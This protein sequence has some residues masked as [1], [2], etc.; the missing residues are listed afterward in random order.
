[1]ADPL[2]PEEL[3]GLV[4]ELNL[5]AGRIKSVI[6]LADGEDE[7]SNTLGAPGAYA[8]KASPLT[9]YGPKDAVTGWPPGVVVTQGPQG[10]SAKQVI[11]AADLLP[12]DATDAEFAT[13][14]ANSQI[15]T[16]QPLL[17]D[18]EAARD[19]AQAARTGA[20]TAET[21]AE[22]A[23][24]SA[25][26]DA[27]ATEA[28]RVATGADRTAVAMD[29]AAAETARAAAEAA[30]TGAVAAQGAG[31]TAQA[32]AEAAQTAAE[33]AQ[34]FAEGSATS[35]ST[36]AAA[37][38]A[39]ADQTAADRV[40]T[41]A[42]RTAV[43]ADRSAVAADA[44]SVATDRAAV[45]AAMPDFSAAVAA[46]EQT[47]L[48]RIAT[49]ADAA[50]TAGDRA[51]VEAA[52]P[53]FAAAVAAAEQTT[54]DAA[55]TAA[56]AVQTGEDRTAVAAGK[57]DTLTAR[58]AALAAQAAAEAARDEAEAIS[59]G[60]FQTS[61]ATLT[62][63]A[64]LDAS[65]G[66]LVQTGA[67]AFAKRPIG[68]ATSTDILD[69]A[70]GDG[71]YA[72]PASI[73]SAISALVDGAPTALDTLN[74]IAAALAADDDAIAALILAVDG[75]QA[76]SDTLTALAALTTTTFGRALLE[77]ADAAALKSALAI[78]IADVSGL[79]TALA[80]RVQTVNGVAPDTSGNV[81]VEA[82]VSSVAGLT[83]AVSAAALNAA[84]SL[85]SEFAQIALT[86][87]DLRGDQQGMSAGIADAFDDQDGVS[88]VAGWT[89]D[90]TNDWYRSSSVMEQ[91]VTQTLPAMTSDAAPSPW[92][93]EGFN[94]AATRSPYRAFNQARETSESNVYRAAAGTWYL[95]RRTTSGQKYRIWRYR[96]ICFA[97][98]EGPNA[99]TLEARNNNTGSW[100]TL[101]TQTDQAWTSAGQS[102]D[103][104]IASGSRGLYSDY[105]L[106]VSSG[107]S[108]DEIE[109][110]QEV[111]ATTTPS[112]LTSTSFTAASAPTTAMVTVLLKVAAGSYALNTDVKAYV[113]RDSGTTW[114]QATLVSGLTAAGFT[115]CEGSVDL[116]GQPTG[117]AVR[118]RIDVAADITRQIDVT[119]VALQWRS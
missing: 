10:L 11:I 52:L 31:E 83:G 67:D 36:S 84:M 73:A 106:A 3:L 38:A 69:R 94:I 98:S 105:R 100:V 27:D 9:W 57:S 17:D 7:P 26:T 91:E 74:E 78:A 99:W 12:S 58:D 28:D 47:A 79:D 24:T 16:V 116:T 29:K 71:R 50:S 39:D 55:S 51:A 60:D 5:I 75:K 41:G 96:I 64:A 90:G 103:Y 86:L 118:Y 23:A 114:T 37:A 92:V 95:E 93:V 63:L 80:A 82:G 113:S 1:M 43:A 81:D 85:P 107:V 34:G 21:N 8:V 46:A 112:A 117:T 61:D 102:R 66:V 32:G 14:L 40:A 77:K 2:T 87:A 35:A 76:A 56:D 54:A 89:Y 62:A 6:V 44:A 68:A 70:A 97:S 59:G 119:G 18:A 65:S 101:D 33:T 19:A 110:H 20:E 104:V 48:D 109:L 25:A 72:T 30:E 49:T 45:D 4:Q 22:A 42:D 115:T 53:D 108:I 15:A 88:S 111:A 13:W